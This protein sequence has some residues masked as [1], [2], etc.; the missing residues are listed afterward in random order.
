M[1]IVDQLT[2][3]EL[4]VK[5]YPGRKIDVPANIL[6]IS[7][8]QHELGWG[9][10]ISLKEGIRKMLTYWNPDEKNFEGR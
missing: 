9:P 1:Q 7:R 10:T 5:R 4:L 3:S 6:D 8:A 2:S